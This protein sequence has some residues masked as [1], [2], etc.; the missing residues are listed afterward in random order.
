MQKSRG[1]IPDAAFGGFL[2]LLAI[3]ALTETRNLTIGTAADMGPGY[4]PRAL[5]LLIMTFGLVIAGRGLFAKRRPLPAIKL[6]PILSVLVSLAAFA[7]LLP[8]GGLALATLATMACSTFSTADYKWRESIIFAVIITAF[9]VFL[10]VY[11]L[12]LPLSIWPRW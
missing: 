8:R 1:D 5:S 12:G 3:V 9:T 10:F 2:I 4:V 11:G 7:L 6:R